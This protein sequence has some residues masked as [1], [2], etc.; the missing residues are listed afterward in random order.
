[1]RDNL[2]LFPKRTLEINGLNLAGSARQ[3]NY[4]VFGRRRTG[5]STIMQQVAKGLLAQGEKVLYFGQL[6]DILSKGFYDAHRDLFFD[7]SMPDSVQWNLPADMVTEADYR[8]LTQSLEACSPAIRSCAYDY[9]ESL[10]GKA[11]NFSCKRWVVDRTGGG[12][13][14]MGDYTNGNQ[15][16]A[17]FFDMLLHCLSQRKGGRHIYVFVEDLHQVPWLSMILPALS[18]SGARSFSIWLSAPSYDLLAARYDYA[19]VEQIV[20][21][22]SGVISTSIDRGTA[23]FVRDHCGNEM[24]GLDELDPGRGA[25]Y[26]RH[27]R[28]IEIQE[29]VAW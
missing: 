26:L 4:L 2:V 12:L 10:E 5:S 23:E 8:V 20:S 22:C 25:V 29:V 15:P 19:A 16:A 18:L 1:M 27:Q 7:P 21:E 6:P 11:G 3:Y 28:S 13:F 14:V 24:A 17:V 9:I